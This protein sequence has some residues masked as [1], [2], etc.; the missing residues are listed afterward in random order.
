MWEYCYLGGGSGKSGV[1]HLPISRGGGGQP[2]EKASRSMLD[3]LKI[4]PTKKM[5]SLDGQKEGK[6]VSSGRGGTEGSGKPPGNEF[7]VRVFGS[8]FFL[9][10]SLAEPL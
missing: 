5:D 1:L 6:I 8:H 3:P 4:I 7:M 9:G 2:P 10:E